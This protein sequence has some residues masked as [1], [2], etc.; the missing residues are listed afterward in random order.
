MMD[1]ALYAQVEILKLK[2]EEFFGKFILI[3]T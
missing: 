1:G 3:P 2:A